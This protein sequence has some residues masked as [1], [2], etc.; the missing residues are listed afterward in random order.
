MASGSS[1][2]RIVDAPQSP[3]EQHQKGRRAMQWMAV[4]SIEGALHPGFLWLAAMIAAV[5]A[6]AECA[7]YA[8]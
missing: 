2:E 4:W 3:I 7:S 8:S 1:P 5:T 6:Q